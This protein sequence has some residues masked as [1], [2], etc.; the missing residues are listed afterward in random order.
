M[1][2]GPVDTQRTIHRSV[3]AESFYVCRDHLMTSI[4][5]TDGYSTGWFSPR[6]TFSDQ[7]RVAWDVNLTDLGGRQWWEVAI[8][9]ASFDSGVAVCPHCA[10]IDWLSPDPSGLPAYPPRSVV[11]GSG[12]GG[13]EV[14][15]STNGV[16]RQVAQHYRIRDFDPDAAASKVIRRPFS[17]V[18]N[19]N[20]TV[21]VNFGGFATYTVP[22]SFPSDGFVVVFKDH[23]YTPT[24]DGPVAGFTWHW[25]NISIT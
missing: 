20:G 4:G 3:K 10:V 1:A 2:C 17:V 24:K 14:K 11:V 21:T 19:R 7:T 22:G 5:D 13:N 6:Q 9:P 25:D 15:V 18:D 23:N 8:V 16:D 12:P